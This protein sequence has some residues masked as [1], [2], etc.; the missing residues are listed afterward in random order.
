MLPM[1]MME[2]VVTTATVVSTVP[3]NAEAMATIVGAV[4]HNAEAT[5]TVVSRVATMQK[6]RPP[7]IQAEAT[8]AMQPLTDEAT[9]SGHDVTPMI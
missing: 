4:A 8:W 6:P 2:N 5:A 1:G 9:Q 7:M 3:H